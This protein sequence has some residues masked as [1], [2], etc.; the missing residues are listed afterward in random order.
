LEKSVALDPEFADA[1]SV[2]AFVYVA[3]NNYEQALS[4][5]KKAV[6]LNPRNQDYFF[7]LAQI[8]LASRKVDTAL[9]ILK[10]LEKSS[11]P[12]VAARATQSVAQAQ[13]FK[14]A[15]QASAQSASMPS[16]EPVAE[17]I[18][19]SGHPATIE[20][21]PTA[22]QELPPVRFLKGKITAVDCSAPP[23]A[24]LTLISRAKTWKLHVKD[25]GHVVVIGADNL[26]CAWKN[27][28]V[29]VNFRAT[30]ATDGD[31]VSV[32]VQ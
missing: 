15:M 3:Q 22:P 12:E 31:V 20:P 24:I 8:Y 4:T 16:K 23:G 27:Q 18:A 11:N 21:Q 25:S 6:A 26:S 14:L 2:L 1:Y 30:G 10:Q 5:M 9:A 19:A 13:E 28:S 7:N 29:A 32:E 17:A